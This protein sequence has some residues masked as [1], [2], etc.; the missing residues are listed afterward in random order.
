MCGT[1]TIYNYS[2]PVARARRCS[3]AAAVSEAASE[4]FRNPPA[5]P[6]A[7]AAASQ[8]HAGFSDAV[9]KPCTGLNWIN[10]LHA[11]SFTGDRLREDEKGLSAEP[12]DLQEVHMDPQHDSKGIDA[13]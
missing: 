4:L 1:I 6:V 11:Q 10:A 12:A 5:R 8:P 7:T 13:S 3:D 9:L 2:S